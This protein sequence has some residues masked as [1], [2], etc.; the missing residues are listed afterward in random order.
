MGRLLLFFSLI[1][2]STSVSAQIFFN[3]GAQVTVKEDALVGI[4]GGLTNDDGNFDNGGYVWIDG[5][6]ENNDMMSGDDGTVPVASSTYVL[7]GDWINNAMF[8]AAIGKVELDTSLVQEI[9]GTS[10]TIFHDL[11]LLGSIQYNKKI[12][13]IDASIGP[14]GTLAVNDAELATENFNM[15]VTNPSSAAVTHNTGFVSSL[16]DAY[17]SWEMNSTNM[18]EFPVG[19]SV[20]TLRKRV[21]RL[22]PG[23]AAANDMGVRF[24]NLEATLEGY[25]VDVREQDIC[26]IIRIFYHRIYQ[27]SGNDNMDI[28]IQY[29]AAEDGSWDFMVN[30]ENIPGVSEWSIT[31]GST[32]GANFISVDDWD[33]F[34]DTAFAFGR[35][36]EATLT[37]NPTS[38][39]EGESSQLTVGGFTGQAMISW[40]Q[41]IDPTLPSGNQT[42]PL[43]FDVTPAQTTT[44][45]VEVTANQCTTTDT[46]TVVV[47][48]VAQLS[49]SIGPDPAVSCDGGPIAFTA[50]TMGGGPTGM[51][52]WLVNG[53]VQPGQNGTTF[54]L[55]N[56][57]NGDIVRGEYTTQAGCSGSATSNPVSVTTGDGVSV[58]LSGSGGVICVPLGETIALFAAVNAPAGSNV[59]ITWQSDAELSCNSGCNTNYVTPTTA[60]TTI[61]LVSIIDEVS[62]C[63]DVDS[64]YICGIDVPNIYV[65]TAF[66]PDGDSDNDEVFVLGDIDLF[67]LDEFRIYNRWGELVFETDTFDEGWDGTFKGTDQEMDVYTWYVNATFIDTGERRELKGVLALLR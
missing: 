55:T 45:I 24:A 29:V 10:A 19:S 44:Y 37:A 46:V 18:Y 21:V 6:L 43:S 61:V 7:R 14:G 15:Y 41:P 57:Q 50:D 66:T 20:G 63:S 30:W 35:E 31:D 49:I 59:S 11:S 9:R 64:V 1:F 42:L 38:I 58:N 47:E 67:D 65:P 16:G 23:T 5:D 54:I 25:D 26:E 52:S 17:I 39:C 33:Y 22:T 32:A 51:I 48:P 53:V 3:N 28:D 13:F 27:L 34:V 60:D 56:P 2:F 12:Q 4:L 8:D 40:L 62:G 36:L